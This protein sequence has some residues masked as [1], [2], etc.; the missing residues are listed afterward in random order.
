MRTQQATTP[1]YTSTTNLVWCVSAFAAT[2]LSKTTSA[3]RRYTIRHKIELHRL[4]PRRYHNIIRDEDYAAFN[5]KQ[6]KMKMKKDEM[7]EEKD[8]KAGHAFDYY[9]RCE[10]QLLQMPRGCNSIL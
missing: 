3:L 10:Y 4:K 9:G 8:V 5:R 6:W 1:I 7:D 2:P